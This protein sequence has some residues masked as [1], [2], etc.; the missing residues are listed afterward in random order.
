MLKLPSFSKLRQRIH[1]LLYEQLPKPRKL[2]HNQTLIEILAAFAYPSAY[3]LVWAWFAN[4]SQ[5]T[6]TLFVVE[7]IVAPICAVDWIRHRKERAEARD[8]FVQPYYY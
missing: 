3:V 7:A 1:Y 6:W 4:L 2:I 8:T 5:Y